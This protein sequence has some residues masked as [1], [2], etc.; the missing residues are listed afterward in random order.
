M[1]SSEH[2]NAVENSLFTSADPIEKAATKLEMLRKKSVP[3]ALPTQETGRAHLR[4]D[5]QKGDRGLSFLV[6]RYYQEVGGYSDQD[7]LSAS[8]AVS[9]QLIRK[10]HEANPQLNP[11]DELS[12]FGNKVTLMRKT[13]KNGTPNYQIASLEV[14][15]NIPGAPA[16]TKKAESSRMVLMRE[17]DSSRGDKPLR[18][19]LDEGLKLG[20][21]A[22]FMLEDKSLPHLGLEAY[23]LTLQNG[24]KFYL[25]AQTESATPK[26]R[27]AEGD[28]TGKTLVNW[29]SSFDAVLSQLV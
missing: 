25:A 9:A 13:M 14:E 15:D 7:A 24:K 10:L 16:V 20:K 5:P 2:L 26:F 6:K 19:N 27:L 1:P 28:M 29:D 4:F 3:L 12:I 18:A 23:E 21:I 8:L 11:G 17:V 22:G